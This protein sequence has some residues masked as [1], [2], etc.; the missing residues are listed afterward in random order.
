MSRG[1][2]KIQ[3]T[4]KHNEA[5]NKA[6]ILIM[7][8]DEKGLERL[9]SHLRDDGWGHHTI[10]NLLVGA[11]VGE[12]WKPNLFPI[13]VHCSKLVEDTSHMDHLD[14]VQLMTL[15]RKFRIKNPEDFRLCKRCYDMFNPCWGEPVEFET[16]HYGKCSCGQVFHLVAPPRFV[17]FGDDNEEFVEGWLSGVTIMTAHIIE[18]QHLVYDGR[19]DKCFEWHKVKINPD[20]VDTYNRSFPHRETHLEVHEEEIFHE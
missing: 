18:G 5:M 2:K 15:I 1:R 8:K 20:I 6:S 4:G 3:L 12:E 9:I 14:I 17:P 10:N 16:D 11:S 13:C 7:R 19:C